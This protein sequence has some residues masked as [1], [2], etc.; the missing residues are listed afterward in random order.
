MLNGLFDRIL[1]FARNVRLAQFVFLSAAFVLGIFIALDTSNDW[2]KILNFVTLSKAAL[3]LVLVWFLWAAS[4][5]QNDANDLKID[6][7]SNRERPLVKGVFSPRFFRRFATFSYAAAL[8]TA[9]LLD[10]RFALA[11]ATFVLL[12]T[13]YNA[14]PFRL[15]RVPVL[16]TL[17]AAGAMISLVYGGFFV[18]T[19]GSDS[20]VFP[21]GF[22]EMF[23]AAVF[24]AMIIPLKDFKDISGDCADNVHT[25]P[26]LLGKYPTVAIIFVG[27]VGLLWTMLDILRELTFYRAAAAVLIGAV[28][29]GILLRSARGSSEDEF[30]RKTLTWMLFPAAATAAL[31]FE[32]F[33]RRN[34]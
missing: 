21:Y 9:W 26:V 19:R 22:S 1:I 30:C 13:L 25:L 20:T 14:R 11:A 33:L 5:S 10:E 27:V 4:V 34:F 15:K 3:S 7:I 17:I 12:N 29:A 24:L 2:S 28:V 6:R 31:L 32:I 18:A 8:M 16:A 23:L